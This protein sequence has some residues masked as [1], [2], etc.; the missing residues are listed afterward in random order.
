M[1]RRIDHVFCV[2]TTMRQNIETFHQQLTGFSSNM[3]FPSNTKH[4]VENYLYFH[5]YYLQMKSSP[6]RREVFVTRSRSARHSSMQIVLHLQL[7]SLQKPYVSC[8]E[9]DLS[10]LQ[11]FN[12]FT[13]YRL[14][15]RLPPYVH[16][17]SNIFQLR[18]VCLIC[19]PLNF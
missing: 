6:S 15:F 19:H 16:R 3:C 18:T 11:S 10:P 12:T 1:F 4:A 7:H 2:A 14:S 17:S 13:F 9:I 8:C 5:L